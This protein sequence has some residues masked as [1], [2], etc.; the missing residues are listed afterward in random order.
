MKRFALGAIALVLACGGAKDQKTTTPAM[1]EP[2]KDAGGGG[3]VTGGGTISGTIKFTGTAPANPKIDMSEEPACKAKYST[4]PTDPV[5]VVHDGNLQNVFIYVK[6]GLPADQKFAAPTKEAEL[7]QEGCLYQPR[8]L[9]VMVNQNIKIKNGDPVLHNIKAVPKKNRG[10]N[11]SQ[12]QQGMTT[13]RSFTTEEMPIPIECNVHGWMHGRVFVMTHPFFSVSDE[14]G[15]FKITGLP[16]GTYTVEAWH[17]KLGT[18]TAQ[19]TVT[20]KGEANA[21]FTFGA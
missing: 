10:F 2:A 3:E 7:N 12:P 8:I 21:S 20:E 19:V 4:P 1:S 5:V 17:E 15:S 11:I 9:G 14:N 18:K 6:S 13:D 16:P